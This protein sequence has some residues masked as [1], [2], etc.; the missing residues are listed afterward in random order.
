PVADV[1]AALAPRL[2]RA[3]AAQ[4]PDRSLP[5]PGGHLDLLRPVQG[6]HLD[7]RAAQRLGDR[8]RHRHLEA[9]AVEALEDGGG[10]DAGDDVEVAGRAAAGAGLAFPGDPDPRPVLDP[11]RDPHLVALGLP[12]EAGAAAGRAGVLDDLPGAAALRAGLADREEALTLG[13]DAAA[14]AARAGDR[15]G[16]G[17][18]TAAAAGRAAF[19]LR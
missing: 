3:L 12:G 4:P 14:F 15:A 9:A 5:G 19:G 1:A 13:V 2:R 18:G 7:R 8:D 11:R 10:G 17:L 6:R 16:A